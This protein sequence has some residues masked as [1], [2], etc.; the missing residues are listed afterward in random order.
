MTNL[1][2]GDT[3]AEMFTA[4]IRDG[5]IAVPRN[6]TPKDIERVRLELNRFQAGDRPVIY[7]YKGDDVASASNITLTGDSDYYHVAGSTTIGTITARP[8]GDIVWLEFDGA[9]TLTHSASLILANSANMV[10]AAGDVM[11]FVSDGNGI[12]REI[13]RRLASGGING[14][15]TAKQVAVWLDADTLTGDSGLTYDSNTDILTAMSSLGIGVVPAYSL[16]AVLSVDSIARFTDS[17]TDAA[18]KISRLAIRH[19]TN[20]EEPVSMIGASSQ[21]SVNTLAFGGG[22]S[23]VNAV[24]QIDFFTAANNTTPTGTSRIRID[25]AGLV[26]I[27]QTVPV[28]GLHV[29]MVTLGNEVFRLESVAT[30]DDPRVSWYQNR[31]AT[32]DNTQTTIATVAIP[33]TTTVMIEAHVVA[34]RTGGVAGTAEDGAAYVVRGCYKNVAGTAT[35]I[36]AVNADY[37]AESQA[38]WDATFTVSGGNVLI[39]VTGATNNNVTWHVTYKYFPV[40]T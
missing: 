10:T 36:G 18:V 5:N 1:L 12:W 6:I 9:L 39:R 33:A 26:G 2:I 19:Y 32:T 17:V 28:A 21:S 24:T 25:S 31:V 11:G 40:G 34:R 8:L 23:L 29:T 22:S 15:G 37:T 16:D 30:N 27:N 35:L 3:V 20:S 14:S 38:G 7:T 13:S 4:L